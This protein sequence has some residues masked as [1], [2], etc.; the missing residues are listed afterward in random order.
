[1]KSLV[2]IYTKQYLEEA[3]QALEQAFT[4]QSESAKERSEMNAYM[5]TKLDTD[6]YQE[7]KSEISG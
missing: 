4:D 7:N 2:E 3:S 6:S 1:M 5:W